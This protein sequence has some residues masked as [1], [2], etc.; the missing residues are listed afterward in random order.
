MTQAWVSNNQLKL[1]LPSQVHSVSINLTSKKQIDKKKDTSKLTL[2][3]IMPR[4]EAEVRIQGQSRLAGP[5]YGG[6]GQRQKK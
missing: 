5:I 6:H 4:R 3:H 2:M 1:I